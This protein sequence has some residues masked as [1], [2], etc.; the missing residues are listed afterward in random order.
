MT[1]ISK[2]KRNIETVRR[3][4]SRDKEGY[5]ANGYNEEG[6]DRYG[7]SREL[8]ERA[9]REQQAAFDSLTPEQQALVLKSCEIQQK[10][11]E[12]AIEWESQ[13]ERIKRQSPFYEEH[14][15]HSDITK[16]AFLFSVWAT[17]EEDKLCCDATSVLIKARNK[18]FPCNRGI[19]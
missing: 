1:N 19:H 2:L 13:P 14:M 16:H 15:I 7:R 3:A 11:E 9:H 6:F 4:L 10:Y 17:K 18:L 12:K 5:D 8:M